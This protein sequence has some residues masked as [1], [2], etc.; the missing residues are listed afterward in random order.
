MDKLQD[1]FKLWL[2][3]NISE[4]RRS[5]DVCS[6][7][8]GQLGDF[9]ERNVSVEARSVESCSRHRA[10]DLEV[11]GEKLFASVCRLNVV[12][13]FGLAKS[14]ESCGIAEVRADVSMTEIDDCGVMP[15][16]EHI[17][18]KQIVLAQRRWCARRAI[19][20]FGEG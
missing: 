19:S 2:R 18:R 20:Q 3:G 12:A 8:E 9:A 6:E 5:P 15:I 7:D 13:T 10:D 1:A 16:P 17:H 14:N 4:F 11:L